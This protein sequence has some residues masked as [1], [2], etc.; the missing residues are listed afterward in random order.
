MPE[1]GVMEGLH[2]ALNVSQGQAYFDSLSLLSGLLP[3]NSTFTADD[4]SNWERV[5]GLTNNSILPLNQRIAAL[6][7]RFAYVPSATRQHYTFL[8]GQLRL[9]GF[10]IHVYENI[11]PDG[12]GGWMTKTPEEISGVSDVSLEHGDFE[13][14]TNEH[15]GHWPDIVA[16]SIYEVDDA[17]FGTGADLTST[18]FIGGSTLGSFANVSAARKEEF[19]QIILQ[20]KPVQTIG[21]LLINY[22]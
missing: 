17:N 3:D 19:R 16:N 6:Y 12:S 18:F 11:F 1:G 10:D 21:F 14:G 20:L 8:E 13:H 5:Y 9:A 22:I 7:Q 2:K 4:A 15:G